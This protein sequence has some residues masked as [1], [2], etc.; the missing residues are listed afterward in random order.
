MRLILSLVFAAEPFIGRQAEPK[1]STAF[2][3][4][5]RAGEK[6]VNA[7]PVLPENK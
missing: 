4:D 7:S 1:G 3:D 5:F 6:V 2:G